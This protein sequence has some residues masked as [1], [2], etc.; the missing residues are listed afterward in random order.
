VIFLLALL[1]CK[2][3]ED[4]GEILLE[5]PVLSH[6]PPEDSFIAG[7]PLPL[8]VSAEDPEGVAEVRVYWRPEEGDTWEWEPMTG[9]GELWAVELS[10]ESPGL[11]YYFK[12]TDDG[13]PQAVSYLPAD[14]GNDPYLVAALEEALP[15]PFEEGFEGVDDLRDLGWVAYE[16]EFAGYPWELT[17]D[18]YE[19][20]KR[21]RHALGNEDEDDLMDDW[22][23]SPALDFGGVELVQVSWWELGTDTDLADHELWL[24]TG[25]RHPE[26]GDFELVT[27][28][29]PPEEDWTRS[30]VIDLSA[31]VGE[32]VVYL[33][34]RYQGA[35]AD[36]W[37]LDAISVRELAPDL[38]AEIT[39]SPD[40]VHPGDEVQ[41]VVDIENAV[42][43]DAEDVL[44]S[45]S[46]EQD[47]W[48]LDQS[49]EI[50]TVAA[51]GSASCQFD[52]T[53]GSDLPDNSRL[54]LQLTLES[55][56]DSWTQE[57]LLQLGY[58]S[59]ASFAFTLKETALM[60][61][62]LGA[63][64]PEDPSWE[65]TVLISTIGSGTVQADITDQ[66]ALLPPAAGSNRWYA[67]ITPHTT[68][69]LDEFSIEHGADLYLASELPALEADVEAL[70]YL[71]SPPA[72]EL[73]LLSPSELEPGATNVALDIWLVNNGE[74]TS[75]AVQVSLTSDEEH[76][77]IQDAGPVEVKSWAAGEQ[78][79]L[80][81]SFLFD[82]DASHTDSQP[83][84]F[85]LEIQDEVESFS[86]DLQIE[87]PWTVLKIASVRIDDDDNDDGVLDPDEAATLEIDV[88]NVGDLDSDGIVRGTLMV[89]SKADVE[90]LSDEESF[91]SLDVDD[92][93]DKDF[94]VQV[95]GGAEGDVLDLQLDLYDGRASYVATT[96]LVLGEPP[97]TSVSPVDDAIGD[98]VGGDFDIVNIKYRVQD[99]LFQLLC[100]SDTKFDSGTLFLEGWG[101]SS[102]AGYVL[103][104]LVLQSGTASLLGWPDYSSHDVIAVPAVSYP[105]ATSVL[106]EWDLAAMDL[107]IDEFSMG[108]GVGWCGPP[109][110]YCD[111]FPD[112]WG[113]PYESYDPTEWFDMEW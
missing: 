94:E 56:Q 35:A 82:L 68:G 45:L 3:A 52:F 75:G 38:S 87:V 73:A 110:Y 93:R 32:P 2:P 89:Q 51:L 113:Y 55:G 43:M 95:T 107:S 10:A 62:V 19:G 1:A 112:A 16:A 29:E 72:P 33:A 78:I 64:D 18:A 105:D 50:G 61:V 91:G 85:V 90:V 59:T 77:V 104:Q 36:S 100:E 21:V 111:H 99:E 30:A 74:A 17:G 44:V 31:W 96:Q 69:T 63:G 26:D 7:D 27:A 20:D 97:W 84:D 76:V 28:L 9:D 109:E 41:L 67:R 42:D 88:V 66:H 6:T 22:L 40:P 103:F 12:G 58:P 92:S 49:Q 47:G 79:A 80:L 83:L 71:P 24:S 81:R 102:G 86:V 39:V 46:A 101:E 5:G 53:L 25:S 106:L 65:E 37:S 34:W 54:P 70:V 98:T 8:E 14:A 15:L 108:W 13:E 4:T 11:E 60:E 48:T 57:Y 23:I